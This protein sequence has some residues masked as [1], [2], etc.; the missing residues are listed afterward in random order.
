MKV[1]PKVSPLIGNW[2]WFGV[3]RMDEINDAV[4]S[5]AMPTPD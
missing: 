1:V 5:L 2:K 4:A 3:K